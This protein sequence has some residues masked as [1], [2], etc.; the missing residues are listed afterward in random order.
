MG[1][2]NLLFHL[3]T[4]ITAVHVLMTWLTLYAAYPGTPP[5]GSAVAPQLLLLPFHRRRLRL[6]RPPC[7]KDTERD[8]HGNVAGNTG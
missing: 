5:R 7:A 8:A 2:G 3:L 6:H 1:T 4:A